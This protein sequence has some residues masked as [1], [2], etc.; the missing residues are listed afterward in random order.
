M[1]TTAKP[2]HVISSDADGHRRPIGVAVDERLDQGRAEHGG[3][4]LDDEQ[5]PDGRSR[6]LSWTADRLV[7]DVGAVVVL[8]V[9]MACPSGCVRSGPRTR[10]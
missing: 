7:L 3:D 5:D 6:P 9:V 8:M 10:F 1:P 2:E 4:H